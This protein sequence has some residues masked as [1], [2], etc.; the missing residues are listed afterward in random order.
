MNALDLAFW[1]I[2]RVSR[3]RKSSVE[4]VMQR[5]LMLG[6]LLV[7]MP[8]AADDVTKDGL[9]M[10]L[11]FSQ[12]AGLLYA[13]ADLGPG[14]GPSDDVQIA[15][16]VNNGWAM[17]SIY[18][19]YQMRVLSQPPGEMITPGPWKKAMQEAKIYINELVASNRVHWRSR[20]RGAANPLVAE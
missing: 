14:F 17:A 18:L 13:L 11:Q 19:F 20:L 2:R 3:L 15:A 10:A 6:A 4:T 12:C 16:E 1:L 5:L 8:V 9:T 7:T